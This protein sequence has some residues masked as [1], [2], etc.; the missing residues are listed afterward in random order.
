MICGVVTIVFLTW[1]LRFR[2]DSVF[3]AL[4]VMMFMCLFQFRSLVI[5]T[6]RYFAESTWLS[7]G[8]WM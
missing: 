6:P 2:N 8:S 5:V 1:V 3:F 7:T 4:K